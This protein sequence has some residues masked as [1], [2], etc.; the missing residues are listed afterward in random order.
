LQYTD[1]GSGA[2][3]WQM[4]AVAAVAGSFYLRKAIF[5][6]RRKRQDDNRKVEEVS[7]SQNS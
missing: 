1:P 4:L 5:F 7:P 2:L 3:L 6:F